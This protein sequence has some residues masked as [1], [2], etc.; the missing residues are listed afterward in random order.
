VIFKAYTTTATEKPDLHEITTKTCSLEKSFSISL[1]VYSSHWQFIS[2]LEL[3]R[4]RRCEGFFDQTFFK[5]FPVLIKLF[6]KV[7]DQ[8]FFEKVCVNRCAGL[9]R[10]Y[11]VFDQTFFEKVCAQAFFKKACEK[12]CGLRDSGRNSLEE[13]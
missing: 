10:R 13:W 7:F 4:L 6:L 2:Y 12:A 5:S 9:W 1:F 11:V 8:T 3:V